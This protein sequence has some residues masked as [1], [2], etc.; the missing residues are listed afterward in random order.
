MINGSLSI[1]SCALDVRRRQRVGRV[2]EPEIDN[3]LRRDPEESRLRHTQEAVDVSGIAGSDL[4]RAIDVRE[5][6]R[7]AI[8]ET[9]DRQFLRIGQHANEAS[10]RARRHP[11]HLDDDALRGL[12]EPVV[13]Q[14]L[15]HDA[16]L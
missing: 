12:P 8:D 16:R 4:Q 2:L 9:I 11:G 7:V 5:A 14:A 10:G 1:A 13:V 6:V 15:K 3:I